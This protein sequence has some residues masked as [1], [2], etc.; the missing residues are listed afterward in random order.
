MAI[1]HNKYGEPECCGRMPWTYECDNPRCT[2]EVC[3]SY[4]CTKCQSEMTFCEEGPK[5]R[6][7]KRGWNVIAI[8]WTV[9]MIALL[10]FVGWLENL[11]M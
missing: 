3:W 1:T 5:W 7:T 4:V 2:N 6:I 10:G 9:G 11:G 8:A